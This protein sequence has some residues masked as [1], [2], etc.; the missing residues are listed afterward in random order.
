MR[1]Y[2]GHDVTG[3]VTA[4]A[5][6]EQLYSEL[7]PPL[8]RC[9]RLGRVVPLHQQHV[10][11]ERIRVGLVAGLLQDLSVARNYRRLVAAP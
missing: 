8:R 10:L 7:K 5:E 9:R 6:M 2:T 3:A 11:V 4:A 1:K